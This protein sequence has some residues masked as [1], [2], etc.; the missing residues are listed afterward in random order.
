MHKMHFSLNISPEK[1]QS[2]YAGAAKSVFVQ[3]EDGRTLNFPASELQKFI[4]PTG[5]HGRF[6]ICFDGDFKLIELM[7]IG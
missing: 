5:I 6:E 4:S 1:Y 7:R 2:Y 3:T